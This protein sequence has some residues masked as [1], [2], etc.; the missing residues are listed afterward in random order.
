MLYAYMKQL[1]QNGDGKF[2]FI[3]IG[4]EGEEALN[5][6]RDVYLSDDW[7]DATEEEYN[8]SLVVEAPA[9][10]PEEPAAETPAEEPAAAPEE[11]KAE[12][13]AEPQ[14]EAAPAAEEPRS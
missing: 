14:A 4:A 1:I 5:V 8:A 6:K 10:V 11:P 13:E 12:A 2:H 9:P 3:R 7:Q